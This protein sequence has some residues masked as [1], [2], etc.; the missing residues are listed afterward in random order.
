VPKVERILVVSEERCGDLAARLAG[1]FAGTRHVM[2]TVLPLDGDAGRRPPG[3]RTLA[4]VKQSA[5]RGARQAVTES[6]PAPEVPEVIVASR[7]ADDPAQA[8]LAESA[9]GYDMIFV[10]MERPAPAPSEDGARCSAVVERIAREFAGVTAIAIGPRPEPLRIM[11]A[12]TGTD[13]SR[14]AAEVAVAIARGASASITVLHVA[15]P[16]PEMGLIRLH[17]EVPVT[18]R[19]VVRE[20]EA[21]ARREN[22]PFRSVVRTHRLHEQAILREL[23]AGQHNLLV[24][25]VNV[26]PGDSLFLGDTAAEILGRASCALLL[27][28]S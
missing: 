16:G 4:A 8:V 12:V 15:R 1:L 22:V 6:E 5:E 7:T 14:R 21:L 2:T 13:Y 17:A 10:G 27:V 20:I 11:V 25:G 28:K 26:R 19:A 23:A 3:E 18:A 24:L 9:K